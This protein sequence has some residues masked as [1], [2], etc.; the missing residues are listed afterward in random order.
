MMPRM[1]K[2]TMTEALD[3]AGRAGVAV[4]CRCGAAVLK[5]KLLSVP[6][7]GPP[8]VVLLGGLFD[9]MEGPKF[10]ENVYHVVHDAAV[11]TF[12]GIKETD[13]QTLYGLSNLKNIFAN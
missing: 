8:L 4:G 6:F 5:G 12:E 10:A 11:A 2:T 9:H 7:F 3:K 13:K 1:K